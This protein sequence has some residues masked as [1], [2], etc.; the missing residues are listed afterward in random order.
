[1]ICFRSLNYFWLIPT[2]LLQG[3]APT[4]L[5]FAFVLWT[6][7]D[8]YQHYEFFSCYTKCCDLLS[9][10]ELLL[11]DT[12]KIKNMLT[13]C[14]V[15][16]C[17]RSLNYFW[18]IPT[19][20]AAEPS[21]SAL[22]FAFV[23]WTT[24]DWYQQHLPKPF[25]RNSCDLLSF[26]E[27]L[28][29]DTNRRRN[30]SMQTNVVICFRSLNYFWLIPTKSQ[31]LN[32]EI[33]LWF[34]FVL[35][36]TFDWYQLEVE[37]KYLTGSCDLLSFFELLLIDTNTETGMVKSESVVICFR[38]LNYFWLI[39]TKSHTLNIEIP[40]WFAFVLWTTFDWYQQRNQ[41]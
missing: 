28:L 36:T 10:F 26:F 13:L 14:I 1:M 27:L 7:F 39:P 37:A 24:F 40:L 3:I 32:I 17:F 23:L 19:S 22:W 6:T 15:V 16:I 25:R 31:T 41:E 5:W 21:T 9:F 30:W 4:L 20:A 38:S 29:I 8:W 11:I 33:P 18:L 2:C 34:A 35:W 12:N